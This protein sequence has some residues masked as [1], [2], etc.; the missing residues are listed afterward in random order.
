MLLFVTLSLVAG[1]QHRIGEPVPPVHIGDGSP[2]AFTQWHGVRRGSGGYDRI[3]NFDAV[4]IALERSGAYKLVFTKLNVKSL[5]FQGKWKRK[6]KK[7][8]SLDTKFNSAGEIAFM[9]RA[10]PSR[11]DFWPLAETKP[12]PRFH[13]VVRE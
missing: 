7:T 8:V 11:I 2:I 6:D 9:D 13:F 4:K 12:G 5:V 3:V 10:N 1:L